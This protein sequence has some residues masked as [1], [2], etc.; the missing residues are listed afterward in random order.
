MMALEAITAQIYIA[1]AII[2]S[3]LAV[4]VTV[5][6][7]SIILSTRSDHHEQKSVFRLWTRRQR[8]GSR[9]RVAHF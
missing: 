4:A 2:I 3:I 1:A 7:L 8:S 5:M 6:A 9:K